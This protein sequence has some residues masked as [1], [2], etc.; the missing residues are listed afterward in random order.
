MNVQVLKEVILTFKCQPTNCL[1]LFEH[2]MG[3]VLK[4]LSLPN[5]IIQREK[6]REQKYT[7]FD[8]VCVAVFIVADN[9]LRKSLVLFLLCVICILSMHNTC[10]YMAWLS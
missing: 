9:L 2:F 3:L 7:Y 4:E 5:F 1:S 10:V 6:V 8:G